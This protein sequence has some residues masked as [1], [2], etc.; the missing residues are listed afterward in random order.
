M[1]NAFIIAFILFGIFVMIVTGLGILTVAIFGITEGQTSVVKAGTRNP[2]TVKFVT[3]VLPKV[4]PPPTPQQIAAILSAI[5]TE[6]QVTE[7]I[8]NGEQ[9]IGLNG[10]NLMFTKVS[11]IT[12]WVIITISILYASFKILFGI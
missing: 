9:I 2:E 8:S 6:P 1:E 7:Y 10:R 5:P 4:S 11:L 3:N 12:L